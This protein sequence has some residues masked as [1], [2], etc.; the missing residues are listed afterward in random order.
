MQESLGIIILSF[1]SIDSNVIS[2]HQR[3]IKV[4]KSPLSPPVVFPFIVDSSGIRLLSDDGVVVMGPEINWIRSHGL[5]G[6]I[7]HQRIFFISLFIKYLLVLGIQATA[8]F[9]GTM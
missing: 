5:T 7:I 8:L 9:M 3:F 6:E 1:F 4:A 2:D